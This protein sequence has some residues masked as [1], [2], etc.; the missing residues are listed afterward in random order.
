[1]RFLQ[2]NSLLTL[3]SDLLKNYVNLYLLIFI[4]HQ[5]LQKIELFLMLFKYFDNLPKYF[6]MN[7]T[8]TFFVHHF[9]FF[10]K[11]HYYLFFS[12]NFHL[13]T[14]LFLFLFPI[15]YSRNNL[16]LIL[17]RLTF[18]FLSLRLGLIQNF[19]CFKIMYLKSFIV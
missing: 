11:N 19:I 14:N 6:I 4:G 2:F 1:M 9:F 18:C 3:N 7:F 15:Q 13:K 17:Y 8:I 10:F 16:L 5:E 12:L